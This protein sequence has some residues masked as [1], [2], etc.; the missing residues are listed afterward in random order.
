MTNPLAGAVE[1]VEALV[2]IVEDDT[3]VNT[4]CKDDPDDESVGVFADAGGIPRDLEMT[5]GHVRRARA[6]VTAL[7]ALKDAGEPVGAWRTRRIAEEIAEAEAGGRGFWRACCGCQEAVDGCL[8]TEDYPYNSVFKCHPGAG[9]SE[10]GGLGVIWDDIDY[11][12]MAEE[13]AGEMNSA[14]PSSGWDEAIERVEELYTEMVGHDGSGNYNGCDDFMQAVRDLRSLPGWRSLVEDAKRRADQ[15]ANL[16]DVGSGPRYTLNNISAAL[17]K[18]LLASEPQGDGWPEDTAQ[19]YSTKGR[20]PTARA[21]AEEISEMATN[22]RHALIQRV[23]EII[24]RDR[25]A[26]RERWEK[27]LP[28]PPA[29]QV[30]K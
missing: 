1:A 9:C 7:S 20:G 30:E 15:A 22:D 3:G 8:N 26:I 14:R 5:F 28:P 13:M 16:H 11:A 2:K 18:A 23:A 6:A 24:I 17:A 29:K 27:K 19:G 12:E 25:A 10:C 4:F 21:L